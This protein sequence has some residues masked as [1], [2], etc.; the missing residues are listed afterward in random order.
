MGLS[1]RREELRVPLQIFLNEYVDDD[2]YRCMTYNLS[3][4][5]IYVNRLVQPV[6]RRPVVGLEFEIPGTSEVVWA[7]GEARFDSMDD[8]FHGTGI[9]F[10]GIARK[11]KSLIRDYVHHQR[12]R[13]L[14]R[15]LA[16]VRRNRR[17]LMN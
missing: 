5:G 1:N 2:P 15:L 9:L 13:Q 4:N 17:Y 12:S 16:N 3:T 8:Y 6:S 10:T 14:E 7:R 11:H